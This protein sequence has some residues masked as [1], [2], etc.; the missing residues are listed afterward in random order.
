MA[1]ENKT[2]DE[3]TQEDIINAAR[4]L[5]AL[6]K[7]WPESQ[8]KWRQDAANKVALWAQVLGALEETEAKEDDA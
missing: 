4:G 7:I 3:L 8:A 1:I 2:E 6:A 5:I